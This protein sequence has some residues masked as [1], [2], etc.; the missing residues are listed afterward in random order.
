MSRRDRFFIASNIH[1]T[2]QRGRLFCVDRVGCSKGASILSLRGRTT[3]IG[4]IVK[5]FGARDVPVGNFCPHRTGFDLSIL[6][7]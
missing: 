7:L 6:E 5:R 3:R 1:S 2:V 4:E